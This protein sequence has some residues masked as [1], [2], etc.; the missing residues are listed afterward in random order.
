MITISI[1][2]PA[3]SSPYQKDKT[4]L[5]VSSNIK[6]TKDSL[7]ILK[8]R[9]GILIK[10]NQKYQMVIDSLNSEDSYV[11][12]NINTDVSL[13]RSLD[14]AEQAINS[15]S[16]LIDSFGVLY[17]VITTLIALGS[18]GIY[19][20]SIKP[21]IQ[22]SQKAAL[23]AQEA[24]INLNKKTNDFN[25]IVDGKLDERFQFFEEKVNQE[26]NEQIFNDLLS[27]FSAQRAI[28]LAQL[29]VLDSS[30][31]EHKH[32]LKLFDILR[33]RTFSETDKL[34]IIEILIQK[35]TEEVKLFFKSWIYTGVTETDIK[36]TLF[37][38]YIS[39]DFSE[40]IEPATRM[41]LSYA[42]PHM[43]FKDIAMRWS[44]LGSDFIVKLINNSSFVMQLEDYSKN[45]ILEYLLNDNQSA[46]AIQSRVKDS[47]LAKLSVKS[48]E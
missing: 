3:S 43:Q 15:Q 5:Q 13:K 17:T 26:K 24:I 2:I 36:Y 30:R 35:N 12:K 44:A 48:K 45:D 25:K 16:S 34:L 11:N 21:I 47:L 9:I 8:S 22:Q 14:L 10:E 23:D 28:A 4:P 18:F 27:S 46:M 40:F 41:L 29:S 33:N 42:S 38:Y 20:F 39:N 6:V 32:I 31:I 7:L 37:K 1:T 19:F